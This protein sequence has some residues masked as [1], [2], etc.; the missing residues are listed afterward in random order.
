MDETTKKV[1]M[2]MLIILG[3]VVIGMGVIFNHSQ[4]DAYD[5]ER[6]GN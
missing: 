2:I 5:W 6:L 4:K 3:V 1:L